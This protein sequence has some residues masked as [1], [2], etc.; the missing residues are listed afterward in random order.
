MNVDSGN[1]SPCFAVVEG[2]ICDRQSPRLPDER[3]L[4]DVGGKSAGLLL[5]QPG[6]SDVHDDWGARTL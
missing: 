4:K 1:T 5:E 2:N 6:V 3:T